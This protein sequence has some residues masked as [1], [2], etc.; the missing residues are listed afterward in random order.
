MSGVIS[1][2]EVLASTKMHLDTSAML[3]HQ[4]HRII[5]QK[6]KNNFA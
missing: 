3:R 4:T 5:N 2:P 1:K 6:P